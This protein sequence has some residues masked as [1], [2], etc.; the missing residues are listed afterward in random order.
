MRNFNN[1]TL[2]AQWFGPKGSG[3]TITRAEFKRIKL[4]MSYSKVKY[5][6]GGKGKLAYD[7][8][9]GTSYRWK[10][11]GGGYAV[12]WFDEDMNVESKH[13]YS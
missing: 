9:L 2:Y 11:S 5:L 6:V 4:G 13:W 8:P 12:I 1:H 10:V 3:A 7:G